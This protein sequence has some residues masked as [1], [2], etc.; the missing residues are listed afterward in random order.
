MIWINRYRLLKRTH[1]HTRTSVLSINMCVIHLLHC[2]VW[3]SCPF[4]F[5]FFSFFNFF[6]HN[7]FIQ[8]AT[9]NLIG[10][11]HCQSRGV[12][13]CSS[14]RSRSDSQP[15]PRSAWERSHVP[16]REKR[17]GAVGRPSSGKVSDKTLYFYIIYSVVKETCGCGCAGSLCLT[18]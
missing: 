15:L 1:T 14:P 2:T 6:L 12:W 5:L 10:Q 16:Q 3:I 17:S 7:T 18:G 8:F 9:R 13:H 11:S 4:F